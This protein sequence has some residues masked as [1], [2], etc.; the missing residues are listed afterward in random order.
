MFKQVLTSRLAER[1]NAGLL[2]DVKSF[3]TV[4]A[5]TLRYRGKEFVNFSS[6]D[7]LG[8]AQ[9]SSAVTLSVPFGATSSP[10]VVGRSDT[11]KNLQAKLLDWVNAPQDFECLL[12]SSGFAANMGVI[13][14]LFNTKCGNAFLFQDRLNHASLLESGSSVQAKGHCRQIRFGHNDYVDLER[15]L[16]QKISQDSLALIATEGVFSM[17]GD[18]PE[19]GSIKSLADNVSGLLMVDDAHGIG[20]FGESGSGILSQQSIKLDDTLIYIVTFGKAVG[21]QG[22]AVFASKDI[23]EYLVNFSK[24]YIYSTHLSPLQAQ[25]VSQNIDVIRADEERRVNLQHNISLFRDLCS[26]C[27]YP[28]LE[29]QSAIQGV[30][31]GDEIKATKLAEVLGNAGIWVNAM[32]YPTVGKGLARLRIT[33]TAKHTENDIERLSKCLKDS[34]A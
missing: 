24:E 28:L 31:I 12:F 13:S 26:D 30:I 6:N 33:I 16:Q 9:D 15:R 29:S 18:S 4:N 14:A 21:A 34:H 20:V 17:D 2:R 32:R 22:A 19:L 7:Y 3:D 5:R 23:I 27:G 11:H 25:A 1:R 10:L 8:V